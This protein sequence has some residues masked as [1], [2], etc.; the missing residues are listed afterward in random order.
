MLIFV[1]LYQTAK[2]A[3]RGQNC[4]FLP[5]N[6]PKNQ[7]EYPSEGC[8]SK[9]FCKFY[10]LTSHM[11]SLALKI[12]K[13]GWPPKIKFH[14]QSI[15]ESPTG[16]LKLGEIYTWFSNN[17]K[18]FRTTCNLT[19]KVTTKLTQKLLF[20]SSIFQTVPIFLFWLLY[21][22]LMENSNFPKFIPQNL[23][24]ICKFSHGTYDCLASEVIKLIKKI[25]WNLI[26]RQLQ[27][28]PTTN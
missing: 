14:L 26:H 9:Q 1:H 19:W 20:T 11:L 2:K 25:K 17:F 16:Q 4:I 8:I 24:F 23:D 18:H 13:L 3:N 15:V 10:I 6:Y 27:N 7:K 5:Q 28:H 12:E 21:H 22:I